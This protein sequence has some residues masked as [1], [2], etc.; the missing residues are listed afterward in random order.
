[1]EKDKTVNTELRKR[2][3]FKYEKCELDYDATV[4]SKITI[5]LASFPATGLAALVQA[6]HEAGLALF[7]RGRVL[8]GQCSVGTAAHHA[9]K[10]SR[11]VTCSVLPGISHVTT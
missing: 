10:A 9:A 6:G 1:M 11:R 8:K 5:P 2:V 3:K 4:S 7:Q